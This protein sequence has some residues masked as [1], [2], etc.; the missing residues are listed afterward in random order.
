M[1]EQVFVF[2]VLAMAFEKLVQQRSV[3]FALCTMCMG[4]GQGIALIIERV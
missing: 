4:V 3:R 1:L 2:Q